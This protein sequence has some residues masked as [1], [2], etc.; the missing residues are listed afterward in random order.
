MTPVD[1]ALTLLVGIV[2]GVFMTVLYWSLV[3]RARN[4]QK[5]RHTPQTT[6]KI[7]YRTLTER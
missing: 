7:D 3:Y 1:F 6:L 5:G 2:L 4:R